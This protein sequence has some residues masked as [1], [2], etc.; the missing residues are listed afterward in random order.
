MLVGGI[1]GGLGVFILII[2]ARMTK[3]RIGEGSR[4]GVNG[5]DVKCPECD[6]PFPTFRIPKNFQQ[7]MW[8]GWTCKQCGEEFDKWL[9]PVPK[10]K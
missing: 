5:A 10:T 1:G 6:N 2:I 4:W 3:L 9:K 8:G 7:A